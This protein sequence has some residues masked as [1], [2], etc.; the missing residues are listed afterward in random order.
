M[1]GVAV[2][3][4]TRWHWDQLFHTTTVDMQSLGLRISTETNSFKRDGF[5]AS[6]HVSPLIMIHYR[7]HYYYY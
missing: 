4:S 7:Y 1:Y 2:E 5:D 6:F 3:M